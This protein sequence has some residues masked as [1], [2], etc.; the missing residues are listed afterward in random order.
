[1]RWILLLF[2]GLRV[3]AQINPLPRSTPEKE[4]VPAKAIMDFVQAAGKSKNELHSFMVVRHGKVIAEGWWNP[5]ASNLKHTLYSTSKSFTA[6]AVGFA[7]SEKKLK[8]TDK[9]VSFFPPEELPNPIP[10]NLAELT[11]KDALMMS[12]G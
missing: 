2:V 8:V 5:Y 1:M 3:S 6:A 10:A 7:V 12:D 4:G 11:V 9:V